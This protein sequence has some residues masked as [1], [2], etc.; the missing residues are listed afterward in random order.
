LPGYEK[1]PPL[2]LPHG[3]FFDRIFLERFLAFQ[4]L[5]TVNSFE[6]MQST[7]FLVD[8]KGHVRNIST[9]IIEAVGVFVPR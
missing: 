4:G 2:A 1:S 8:R 7:E 3:I 5:L 9:V 6:E